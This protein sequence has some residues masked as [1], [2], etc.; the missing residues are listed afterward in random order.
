MDIRG[1][2]KRMKALPT[3]PIMDVA[4]DGEIIEEDEGVCHFKITRHEI[5]SIPVYSISI[6]GPAERRTGIIKEFSRFLGEP[7]SQPTEESSG[8]LFAMWRAS[9]L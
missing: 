1:I 5:A 4:T 2:K 7:F 3:I 8:V 6:S 9:K